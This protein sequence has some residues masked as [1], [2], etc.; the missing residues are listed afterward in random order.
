MIVR[1]ERS[2]LAVGA[3]RQIVLSVA[4]IAAIPVAAGL[5]WVGLLQY[6]IQEYACG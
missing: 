1:S 4:R 5:L 2:R 3:P 6:R